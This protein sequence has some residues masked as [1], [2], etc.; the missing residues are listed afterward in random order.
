MKEEWDGDQ[1]ERPLDAAG[2]EQARALAELL[3]PAGPVRLVASPTRRCIDTLAPLGAALGLAVAV[4]PTLRDASGEDLVRMAAADAGV[5]L[6]THG[7][8]MEPALPVLRDD[9][10]EIVGDHDDGDLLLKGAAWQLD[11]AGPGW[12][13]ALV[14]PIP[15]SSCPRHT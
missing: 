3:A 6:C 15:L 8:V 12:R 11:R 4:E 7:E 1:E 14:A 13:L 2:V 5:V 9:G 10:L